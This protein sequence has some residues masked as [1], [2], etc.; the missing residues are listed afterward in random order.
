MTLDRLS[1]SR[2]RVISVHLQALTSFGYPLFLQSAFLFFIPSLTLFPLLF[3]LPRIP[4][5]CLWSVF[6]KAIL[7]LLRAFSFDS[8]P[9]NFHLCYAFHRRV[10]ESRLRDWFGEIRFVYWPIGL[11]L[12]FFAYS[13]TKRKPKCNR[14]FIRS[15]QIFF[16]QNAEI[17]HFDHFPLY[18][19]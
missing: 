11:Y 9:K 10:L 17:M 15:L 7:R 4:L 2:S 8:P 18:K 1:P 13:I 19:C 16:V 3:S 5:C 12:P 6:G 14:Q